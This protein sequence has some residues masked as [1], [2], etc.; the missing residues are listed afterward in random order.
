MNTFFNFSTSQITRNYRVILYTLPRKRD[1]N[2]KININ[3][4]LAVTEWENATLEM[5]KV[6]RIDIAAFLCIA[7]VIWLCFN[8]CNQL[9]LYGRFLLSQNGIPPSVSKR[10]KLSIDCKLKDILTMKV[11]EKFFISQF[12]Q[13]LLY[14]TNWSE[15]P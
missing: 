7:S 4:S 9:F 12:H 15:Y 2:M 11:N 5:T 3:R 10:I 14:R 8:D 1:D 13:C 6:S